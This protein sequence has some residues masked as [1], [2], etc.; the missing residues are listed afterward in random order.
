[1]IA[2]SIGGTGA[3]PIEYGSLR[4]GENAFSG[5]V[6]YVKLELGEG[7][8]A[9]IHPVEWKTAS[10]QKPDSFIEQNAFP[11]IEVSGSHKNLNVEGLWRAIQAISQWVF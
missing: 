10:Y 8:V 3:T 7:E 11:T 6:T 1:V 9:E 2:A 4:L 5:G